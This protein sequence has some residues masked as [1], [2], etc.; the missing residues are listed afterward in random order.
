MRECPKSV[1]DF[2]IVHERE[3]R[4]R[5]EHVGAAMQRRQLFALRVHARDRVDAVDAE[6]VMRARVRREEGEPAVVRRRERERQQVANHRIN[7]K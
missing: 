3:V 5:D 4:T 2:Q 6:S 1:R 7:N